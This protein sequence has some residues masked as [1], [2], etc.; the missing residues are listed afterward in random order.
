MAAPAGA[1][2]G[3]FE[4]LPPRLKGALQDMAPE[5]RRVI[6]ETMTPVGMYPLSNKEK[7]EIARAMHKSP[8]LRRI[9][10]DL[11]YYYEDE[12]EGAEDHRVLRESIQQVDPSVLP[13]TIKGQVL[14]D[15]YEDE[16][17]A[18]QLKEDVATIKAG[19]ELVELPSS[20]K[21]GKQGGAQ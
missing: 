2:G 18:K 10:G 12:V 16:P 19:K 9:V 15:D 20:K 3:G 1:G 8:Q 11:A 14:E 6:L 13:P 4:S 21:K 5:A 7:I 17:E